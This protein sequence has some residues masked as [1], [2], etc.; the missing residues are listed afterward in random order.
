[1]KYLKLIISISFYFPVYNNCYSQPQTEWV[2]RYNS[3]GNY[4][5][6]V[7]DMAIDNSGNVYITG[8]VNVNDT[9]QNYVTIKYNTQGIEQWV[10]YYDGP[11]HREDKPVAIAVDDSENVFVTGYSYSNN[12]FEDFLTI[13]YKSNGDSLWVRRFNGIG[14][15]GDIARAMALD[16]NGNIYICG[17][18]LT[19]SNCEDIITIKYNTNGDLNWVKTFNGKGNALDDPRAIGIDKNNNI[20]VNGLSYNSSGSVCLK[21]DLFGNEIWSKYFYA[22][23]DYIGI[24]SSGSIYCGGITYG[25]GIDY[26]VLKYDSLGNVIWSRTYD[27]GNI[28]NNNDDSREMCVDESGNVTITGVNTTN[29]HDFDIATVKYNSNGDTL[30]MKKYIGPGL[31]NDESKGVVCDKFGNVY[32]GGATNDDLF[33]VKFL[34]IGYSPLG[35]QKWVTKYNNNPVTTHNIRK[36]KADTSGNIYITGLATGYGNSQEILTIK[37]STVTNYQNSSSIIPGKF[38]LFQNYPN[39]FNPRTIINY[40]LP[41]V[42]KVSLKVFNSLGKEIITLINGVQN[43]GMHKLEFNGSDLPSGIYF[44]TLYADGLIIDTKKLILLK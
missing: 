9:N 41:V 14:N 44:Y 13:K 1:M 4:D 6:Y 33:T 39:P 22:S 3:S 31:S 25:Q 7:T 18:G 8:Y 16:T 24:D 12:S 35:N 19:C 37:Y 34:C 26:C 43:G 21:Y 28:S 17:F 36:I 38:T 11:D 2:Q 10:R 32:V 5:D 15:G 23:W 40:E 42:S 29:A 27:N 20:Y 30:W